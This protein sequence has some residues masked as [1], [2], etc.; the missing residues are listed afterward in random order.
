LT[1]RAC[2]TIAGTNGEQHSKRVY[3]KNG[4]GTR[5]INC[6]LPNDLVIIDSI[7]APW[8]FTGQINARARFLHFRW[9]TLWFGAQYSTCRQPGCFTTEHRITDAPRDGTLLNY[10][11]CPIRLLYVLSLF[12]LNLIDCFF[13]FKSS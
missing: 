8:P 5:P 1:V 6:C 11:H 10:A 13:G 9:E 7:F 3:E 2:T 12:S 4:N